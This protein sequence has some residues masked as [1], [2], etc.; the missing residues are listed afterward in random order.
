MGGPLIRL[1]WGERRDTEPDWFTVWISASTD[2]Q[3]WSFLLG[4]SC[5]FNLNLLPCVHVWAYGCAWVP[6]CVYAYVCV[7]VWMWV[8]QLVEKRVGKNV[9]GWFTAEP[10]RT[11]S[12][13]RTP[14]NSQCCSVERTQQNQSS[15]WRWLVNTI[16]FLTS[17][18]THCLHQVA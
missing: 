17:W 15:P 9:Y 14:D 18:H 7:C 11:M 3:S 6:V 16:Y 12:G 10:L 1:W 4:L 13:L 5:I 8:A 2:V